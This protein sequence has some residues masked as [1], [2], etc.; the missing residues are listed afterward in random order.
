MTS[1]PKNPK[2]AAAFQKFFDAIENISTFRGSE[3]SVQLASWPS[4]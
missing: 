4:N 1:G 2:E 3:T